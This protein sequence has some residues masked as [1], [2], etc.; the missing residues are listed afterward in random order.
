MFLYSDDTDEYNNNLFD[1]N[2]IDTKQDDVY[3]KSDRRKRQGR[4][5]GA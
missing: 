3:Y 4:A 2:D 1:V 5:E